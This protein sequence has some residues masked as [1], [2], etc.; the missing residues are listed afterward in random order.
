MGTRHGTLC[1]LLATAIAW[2]TARPAPSA[3][4]ED[5]PTVMHDNQRTGVT[6]DEVRPPL[7]LRWQCRSPFPP[8]P[9]WAPT[10]NGYGA[11]KNKSDVSYDDAF[12][13]IAA[14]DTAYFCSSAEDCLY[15]V[16]AATGAV[17]WT[18]IMDGTPRLAPAFWNGKLYV[19]A[20]DGVFRCLDAATGKLLWQLK[21]ALTDQQML[22]YGRFSSLWP[23]RAGGIVENGVAYFAAG[24]FPSNHIYLHAVNAEDGRLL[25]RRQADMDGSDEHVPQGYILTRDD[26]LFTTS[27]TTP[28]RWSKADGSRIDFTTPFPQVKEAHEYRFYNGG[29]DARIWNGKQIVYGTACILAYDPDQPTKDSYGRPHKGGLVFNWFNARQ[30]LCKG[31]M[32]YLATDYHLVAVEQSKLPEMANAECKEFEEAYKKLAIAP[33]LDLMEEYEQVIKEHGAEHFRARY[34]ENGP[35]KWGKQNWEKWPAVSDA[36]FAKI[37][38]KCAWMTPCSTATEALIMAGGVL[39]AGGEKTV[40]AYDAAT[41][42]KVW[43]CETNSRVRGLAAAN[44]RLFVSTVDG[45]VRCFAPGKDEAGA[46][47]A[48]AGRQGA[49]NAGPW[50]EAA[51][52]ILEQAGVTRGYALVVGKGAVPLACE[53][54]RTPDLTIQ[55]V[56]A[57]DEEVA[58][59]REQLVKRGLHG[60]RVVVTRCDMKQLPFAPYLFNL[61][62][63][64][65]FLGGEAPTVS[66]EELLRVTKPSGGAAILS[67]AA[68]KGQ[69]AKLLITAGAESRIEGKWLV[70]K[71][72]RL[73]LSKDWTHNYATPANT[74][75][76]EDPLVKG[77]FSVLWYG[78]PGPRSRIE[79]HATPPMPLVV[80][81]VMFTIGYDRVMAYDVYNGLCY[82]ERELEGATRQDLPLNTSNLA[83]DETS[84]FIVT[85]NRRAQR[86]D[87]RTGA[88]L[89]T[90]EPPKPAGGEAYWAWLARDGALLYGSRAEADPQR[91]SPRRQTSN[92]VFALDATTG[93]Q[94]WVREGQGIDH[95]GIAVGGGQVFFVDRAL[96]EAER[97]NALANTIK[98]ASVPDRKAAD[99]KGKQFGPDLRKIVVLDALTGKAVW[100]KPLDC[101]DITLDDNVVCEGRVGIACMYSNGVLVVHGTGSL[102]HPHKEFLAG[103]FA[104]RALYA[105]DAKTGTLLWG[106]RKGYQR[107]PIIAGSRI[108]AEPFAWELKTGK[109]VM[110]ANPLSGREQRLDFHRGYIGCGHMLASAETLF[111]ARRGI[112][113]WNVGDQSGFVPFGGMALACGLCAVPAGGVFVVPEGRSGCTCDTPIHASIVLYPDRTA[114]AWGTG[115]TGGIAEVF[116][117]PVKRVAV[118]LGAPGYRTDAF[119]N[120]W[121]PYPA[122][123]D[124]GPLGKWLPTYQHDQSMCYCDETLAIAGTDMPWVFTSGYENSKPLRF[125]LVDAGQPAATYTVK[126]YFAEPRDVKP[127]ERVFSVR[128]Q[129]K[130]VAASCDIVAEANGPRR[131]LV[132]EFRGI[133]VKDFLEIAL[134][135][136]AASKVKQPL[137]CGFEAIREG[138]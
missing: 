98:D 113:Y 76:S 78:E 128:L 6:A 4:A 117:L 29:T 82:W 67:P 106:G 31:N 68:D 27:R 84:L 91:K 28:A 124:A 100:E 69:P 18:H 87:V 72:G 129:G 10:P 116:P 57:G 83:A 30:A 88:T 94:T 22:G 127:G 99:A 7:V 122:R 58:Q 17:R 32:A 60:G 48:Q 89:K 65:A 86:L 37:K 21:A 119:R 101:S 103:Q 70:V 49:D 61:V 81:G 41:G 59:A 1:L 20:D 93:Q 97:D 38:Q 42:A 118:N 40:E 56:L 112:A 107:R 131:A 75:C 96:T 26:S 34:L 105:F 120:L 73:P 102:G 121:V 85:G 9:G 2:W 123:A 135:P 125:K 16:D 114:Y 80:N 39:Y 19:G 132:K 35:L 63:D 104:R 133:A 95:D 14:G 111:G 25:W 46:A 77:P 74:Y 53:L 136:L 12:R 110:V 51:R 24:L 64:C 15:A 45:A 8:A 134:T 43:A 90:Y 3:W 55:C 11:R 44:G 115:F 108:Y 138:E 109:E 126:L 50:A 137:L 5:W 62:V 54:A 92:A 23:I 130:E 66:A 52:A 13:V 71:R 33:R 79:R 36:I 47:K